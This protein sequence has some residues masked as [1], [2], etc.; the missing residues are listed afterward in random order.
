MILLHHRLGGG[1]NDAAAKAHDPAEELR[2]DRDADADLKVIV[3]AREKGWLV[4]EAVEDDAGEAVLNPKGDEGVLPVVHTE[5]GL[6]I[7]R[8]IKRFACLPSVAGKGREGGALHF[9]DAV[10][11]EAVEFAVIGHKIII[12]VAP[13]QT[14]RADGVPRPL[15][16]VDFLLA[17]IVIEVEKGHLDIVGH[18]GMDG[19]DG[20]VDLFVFGTDTI[21]NIDLAAELFGLAGAD[22]PRELFDK[23][24]AFFLGQKLGRLHRVHQELQLGQLKVPLDDAIAGGAAALVH[25]HGE[26]EVAEG[27][28]VG[29][30]TFALGGDALRR[31]RL[32]QLAAG[33]ALLAV[34]VAEEKLGQPQEL[35]LLVFGFRH[36]ALPALPVM[37]LYC[38]TGRAKMQRFQLN[39]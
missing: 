19:I 38:T 15:V 36:D 12:A 30:D 35:L 20:V 8:E 5:H 11:L 23:I 17:G 21:G 22:K 39:L 24:A 1:D 14:P 29:V 13:D 33:H 2:A 3:A 6:G 26:T 37:L 16:T 34:G 31:Q 7:G 27:L 28:D 4:T 18:G 25:L 10:V 9:V 32:D